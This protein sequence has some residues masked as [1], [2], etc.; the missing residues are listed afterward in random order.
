MA[1]AS[2]C[3][4]NWTGAPIVTVYRNAPGLSV[5]PDQSPVNR[6]V[7]LGRAILG[8]THGNPVKVHAEG[9]GTA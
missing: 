5:G 1:P 8:L 6:H 3:S 4:I 7:Q 2:S 9:N